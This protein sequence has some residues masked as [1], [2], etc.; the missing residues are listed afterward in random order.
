VNSRPYCWITTER[1]GWIL[2]RIAH[3]IADRTTRF[4]AVTHPA[5]EPV[6]D[7]PDC[8]FY[9]DWNHYWRQP[10]EIRRI[11]F[12]ALVTHLDRFAF[13]VAIMAR[14]PGAR[15]ACMSDRYRRML[16]WY[17][18][19]AHKLLL[20]P[21]GI[22]LDRFQPL[23][24]DA[25]GPRIRIGI[26]GRL[27]P[28]GRK[29]E[30]LL[31]RI[32]RRL[33]PARFEIHIV[34]D[35]W[36]SRLANLQAGGLMVQYSQNVAEAELPRHVAALDVLLITSRREGGPIPALEALACG[37]PLVSR[38]VGYVPDL[39]AALP[40]AGGIF[41]SSARAVSLL[42]DAQ[43]MKANLARQHGSCRTMLET[44]SWRAFAH[45]IETALLQVAERDTHS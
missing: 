44:Y 22:D 13:R 31:Q 14:Q 30:V 26:L 16:R 18:V 9:S 1:E 38:P 45:T 36:E 32:V 7:R 24:A 15:I 39:L 33:D 3:E 23:P 21:M 35:R 19:P 4:E 12:V 28:D 10:R 37:V 20:S 34:G 11:P 17:G 43:S 42:C 27:Y 2:R 8:I 25:L 5:R 29:G 6:R 41:H 40:A